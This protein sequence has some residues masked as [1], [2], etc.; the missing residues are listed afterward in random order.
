MNVFLRECLLSCENSSQV[1]Q[2]NT[3]GISVQQIIIKGLLSAKHHAEWEKIDGACLLEARSQGRR[4]N[5][6]NSYPREGT[7]STIL[8]KPSAR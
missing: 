5:A 8:H 6:S 7:S 3:L 2:R 1:I 4:V